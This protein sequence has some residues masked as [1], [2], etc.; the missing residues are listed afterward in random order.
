ME[1]MG[2]MVWLGGAGRPIQ[3]DDDLLTC[4]ACDL[5]ACDLCSREVGS[6]DDS[7]AVHAYGP[8]VIEHLML[9]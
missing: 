5:Y 6:H 2:G 4:D 8:N 7:G 1:G 9:G 3:L